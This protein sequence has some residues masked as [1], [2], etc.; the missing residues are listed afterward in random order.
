MTRYSHHAIS[1]LLLAALLVTAPALGET[2][3]SPVFSQQRPAPAAPPAAEVPPPRAPASL[4]REGSQALPPLGGEGSQTFPPLQRE[5]SQ[6]LPPLQGEG[7]GGDGVKSVTSAASTAQRRDEAQRNPALVY[8]DRV[9]VEDTVWRG[10]VLVE[11]VLAVAPQATLSVEPGTVVRFRRQGAQAPLLVVQGRLVA[12]GTRENPVLFTSNFATAA[13]GDWQGILLL[14]SEKKNQ[15]ENCRIEGAETG[16]D[17]IF[18]SLSLKGVWAEQAGTGMRFQDTVVTMD[19]GGATK[20][21]TA[22][23]FSESEATLRSPS[24]TGNRQGLAAQHSSIYLSEGNLSGNQ[25]AAFTGDAS[26]VK[27]QGGAFLANGSGVTLSGCEGSISGA[28]LA[29][30]REFGLSLAAS[31]VKVTGNVITGNGNNGMIVADG[32]AVAWDNAIFENAGYDLYHAG[33]EEFRAPANWWGGGEPKI[34]DNA[35]RGRV[36]YLPVLAARPLPR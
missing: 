6:T 34:Y 17:A 2:V 11:G 14:G 3:I 25:A 4:P 7:R 21:G 1:G 20:C 22:L 26:R 13:P 36:L 8:G 5:G 27:I 30:N 9:L 33:I 12:V 18:S 32:A 16:I 23:R 10:E 19:A 31:R 29:N 35:G 28:K 24:L 15:L